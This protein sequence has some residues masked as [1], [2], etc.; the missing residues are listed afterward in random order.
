[1]KEMPKKGDMVTFRR[2]LKDLEVR[3]GEVVSTG[4]NAVTVATGLRGSDEESKLFVPLSQ[5]F[6]VR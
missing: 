2:P 1:M 6:Q 4:L 5:V 3:L